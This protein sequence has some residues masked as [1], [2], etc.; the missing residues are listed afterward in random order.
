MLPISIYV[1]RNSHMDSYT[2]GLKDII[3]TGS[4]G[5]KVPLL[6]FLQKSKNIPV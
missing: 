6:T 3:N 5:K 1:V 4:Y 2:K